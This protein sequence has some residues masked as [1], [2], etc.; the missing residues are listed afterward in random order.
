[1]DRLHAQ[2]GDDQV[3]AEARGGGERLR[4]ALHG[5]AVVVLGAQP[6]GKQAQQARIVI[7]DQDASLAP[8][9]RTHGLRPSLLAGGRSFCG[10][11]NSAMALSFARASSSARRNCAFCS[12]AACSWRASAAALVSPRCRSRAC[13][14]SAS[15]RW[16]SSVSLSSTVILS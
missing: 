1:V 10:R 14:L 11:S 9:G 3:G 15:R 2:V 13:W 4:G 8:G 6:D 16:F 7:D 12:C 5:L